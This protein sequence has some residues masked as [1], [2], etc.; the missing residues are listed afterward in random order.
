[1]VVSSTE[2][3]RRLAEELPRAE[4]AV[5]EIGCSTGLTTQALARRSGQVVAV[6]VSAEF[7]GR[8][9]AA[10]ADL[11]NVAVVQLD[12][13]DVP[14]LVALLPEPDLVFVDIGGDAQ[15]DN[16]ALQVRQCLLAFS[17]RVLVVKSAEL[18]ALCSLVTSHEVPSP[19]PLRRRS[20][21][22]P[23]EQLVAN[24]LDLSRSSGS[25]NRLYAARK[26][27]ALLPGGGDSPEV[28]RR[29]AE[30]AEGDADPRV[31]RLARMKL[32]GHR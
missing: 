4:D 11:G 19:F 23:G 20:H 25:V 6:D 14:G 9:R 15:L 5:L 18:A 7:V 28:E 29:L 3:Y 26:L 27:G 32:E 13:R 21:G 12:G 10:L 1:M 17:P 30:M 2:A 24:L 8:A 16:V 22:S 31:R